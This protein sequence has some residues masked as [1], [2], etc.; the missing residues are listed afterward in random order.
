MRIMTK[1]DRNWLETTAHVE[2]VTDTDGTETHLIP[3]ANWGEFVRTLT[4]PQAED[5]YH[6]LFVELQMRDRKWVAENLQ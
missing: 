6:E 1:K 5:L 2:T 3:L 4:G